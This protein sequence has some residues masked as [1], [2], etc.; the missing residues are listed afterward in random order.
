MSVFLKCANPA[1]GMTMRVGE[2][3]AGRTGRCPRC[4][5]P[6]VVPGQAVTA[7]TSHGGSAGANPASPRVAVA[8]WIRFDVIGTAWGLYSQQM[9]TWIL[10]ALLGSILSV[11]VNIGYAVLSVP[12]Q[13]MLGPVLGSP[14]VALGTIVVWAATWSMITGAMFRMALN[15]IDRGSASL[16]D[17]FSIA[18]L[19]PKLVLAAVLHGLA[20]CAGTMCLIVPG[21]I[22][23]G[24]LMF[25]LP[26]VVD[27]RKGAFEA[28]GES[29]NT[30]KNQWGPA[31]VFF[32]VLAV[33][34]SSGFVFFIVGILLT[35]PLCVLS[36]AL[37]YRDFFPLAEEDPSNWTTNPAADTFE[38]G[39]RNET[40]LSSAGGPRPARQRQIPIWAWVV[41]FFGLILPPV[42]VAA[43]YL[44][45]VL[46]VLHKFENTQPMVN[47]QMENPFAQAFPKPFLRVEPPIAEAP[48][49]ERPKIENV[50]QA[51]ARLQADEAQQLSALN[52]LCHAMPDNG[53]R[54]EVCTQ[55]KPLLHDRSPFVVDN[56][57][58]ALAVWIDAD[59][60]PILVSALDDPD[61]GIRQAML[62]TLAKI[63]HPASIAA[64][65][66]RLAVPEDR[67]AARQALISMGSVVNKE[68]EKLL[69]NPDRQVRV[70]A[71]KILKQVTE[72]KAI[73][74]TIDLKFALADF[75]DPDDGVRLRAAESFR[76]GNPAD[77]PRAQIA[78]ALEGLLK[79]RHPNV[80]AEAARQL[81]RW[82]SSA[83]VPALIDLLSDRDGGVLRPVMETLGKLQDQRAAEPIAV[84]LENFFVREDAARALKALGSRAENEVIRYLDHRDASVRCDAC[85]ILQTIG[86]AR[87]VPMLMQAAADRNRE[88]SMAAGNALRSIGSKPAVSKKPRGKR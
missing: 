78:Q 40:A 49:V 72:D 30:L 87:S 44:A 76:R 35:F 70:E 84:Y 75:D 74:S 58:Q 13:L 26:L 53:R 57:V 46:F 14:T 10:A 86:T 45:I 37:L 23:G 48:I 7:S 11:A 62:D 22:I 15:Q 71:A 80:R 12:A 64:I 25:T 9:G 55:L 47:A 56:T 88:V 4:K 77:A 82:G 59:Q 36:H 65:A 20:I 51:L 17:L 79:D 38:M 42:L 68:V 85:R 31:T 3:H 69:G 1:C 61:A 43:S 32:L 18:D 50:D 21:W 16:G 5:T 41:L 60:L 67:S 54:Q 24:L 2:E 83:N 27:R 63:E 81:A 52:W 33:V 66:A 29:W 28:M 8:P 39:S 73:R 34:Q 6:T 19:V